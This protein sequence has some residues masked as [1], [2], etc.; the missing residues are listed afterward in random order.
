MKKL[1]KFKWDCGRMGVVDSLFIALEENV[2]KAIG[3][4]VD[5]GEIL[6]KHSNVYGTLKQSDL[7]IVSDDQGFIEKLEEL[8]ILPTGHCP[9]HNLAEENE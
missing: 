1:Y 2:E 8:R 4:Q 7:T 9:L 3:A 6:G 5:F